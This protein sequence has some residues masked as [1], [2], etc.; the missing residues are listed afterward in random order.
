MKNIY[1]I[2]GASGSGKTTLTD[3]LNKVYGLSYIES[4]TTRPRRYPDEKGHI[5]ITDKEFD[6]LGPMCSY[7][8]YNGYRYGVTNKLIDDH[9]LFVVDP[10]GVSYLK[11]HY[12]GNK[13]IVVIFLDIDPQYRKARM[14][15]RG[16]TYEK[17]IERLKLDEEWFDTAKFDFKIDYT[18]QDVVSSSFFSQELTRWGLMSIVAEYIEMKEGI[19]LE[20][21]TVI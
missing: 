7:T 14:L 15:K 5:F 8:E 16:D 12:K 3:Y 20:F 10:P 6:D 13:G 19:K 17:I 4:Y 11:E 21:R 2:V 18:I 9:D 1:L